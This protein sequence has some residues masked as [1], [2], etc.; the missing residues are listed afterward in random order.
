MTWKW[1][2]RDAILASH[3]EQLRIHGGAVGLRDEGALDSALARGAMKVN[4]GDPDAAELAAA[5]AYGI[6]KNHPFVDG[7]KRTALVAAGVFL[8]INGLRLRA[9]P[10]EAATMIIAMAASEISEEQ[11]AAWIRD[12]TIPR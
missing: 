7:N 2:P 4:Y 10:A 12:R 5:Y 3:A 6:A 8:L 1:V 11:L 9:A